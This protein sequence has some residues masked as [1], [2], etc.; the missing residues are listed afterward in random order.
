ME[1]MMNGQLVVSPL[2]T[3]PFELSVVGD[4]GLK[5]RWVRCRHGTGWGWG[6]GRG[7]AVQTLLLSPGNSV[8]VSVSVSFHF[9]QLCSPT[10]LTSENALYANIYLKNVHFMTR[11]AFCVNLCTKM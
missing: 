7:G 5:T 3:L 11:N 10:V 2:A 6:V 8:C 1:V 9:L 4:T